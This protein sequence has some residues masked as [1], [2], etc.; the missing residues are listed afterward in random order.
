MLAQHINNNKYRSVITITMTDNNLHYSDE[1]LRA[2]LENTQTIAL[3]GA[4]EKRHR[5]SY[6]VMKFLQNQ[7]YRVIPVN[8]QLSGGELLG[9]KVYGTLQEIPFPVDLVD[10]FRHSAAAAEV[11]QQAIAIAPNTIWMQLGVIH[12]LAA[13]T[14][15]SEGITVIMD[16]CPKIEYD[17]L[18]I[19]RS[20][21]AY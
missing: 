21:A 11:T 1:E 18:S 2:I 8:P 19:R 12:H 9:E 13:A 6:R 14:A 10:I 4:S 15:Q 5:A 17:R 3:V 16:R 7:D 20:Q